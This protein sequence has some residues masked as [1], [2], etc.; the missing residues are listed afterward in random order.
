MKSNS[1]L[2]GIWTL[3]SILTMTVVYAQNA[4]FIA[5][6]PS[7]A[8]SRMACPDRNAGTITLGHSGGL[9]N[10]INLPQ[11][12]LC[13]G[14]YFDIIH[15][16]DAEIE[17][18]DP[19]PLTAPGIG[20]VWYACAPTVERSTLADILSDPCILDEPAPSMGLYVYLDELNGNA[21]FQNGTQIN[22]QS[23]PDFYNGGEPLEVWFAPITVDAEN[24]GQAEFEG[25]PAGPCVHVNT[26]EAFSVVYLTP[27]H[28]HNVRQIRDGGSG[29]LGAF[30]LTGGLPQFDANT[31]YT[32]DIRHESIPGAVGTV[33]NGPIG[34]GD[35]VHFSFVEE[36]QY[37]IT[38]TDDKACPV[39][40]TMSV[41][42]SNLV[43]Y[44]VGNANVDQ[45]DNVC[46]PVNLYGFN[47]ISGVE[48]DLI[49]DP[50]VFTYVSNSGFLIP[51]ASLSV[52]YDGNAAMG[53]LRILWTANELDMGE[54]VPDGDPFFEVCL[55]AVGD[56]YESTDA[57]IVGTSDELGII[58][59]DTSA[60]GDQQNILTL[61]GIWNINIGSFHSDV[62][63]CP[64]DGSSNGSALID[65]CGGTA[66][67]T[68]NYTGPE[69]GMIIVNDVSNIVIDGLP[70]G[71]YDF[72]ITDDSGE[73]VS[74][75]VTIATGMRH[76]ISHDVR[77]PSCFDSNDGYIDL[78]ISPTANY[79]FEW[80]NF[81]FETNRVERLQNGQYNV[82]VTDESGCPVT[83]S[84]TLNTSELEVEYVVTD[85]SCA[86]VEDGEI[87]VIPHGG[88]PYADGQ[89]TIQVVGDAA[90]Q[91]DTA[92]L[93]RLSIGTYVINVRDRNACFNSDTIVL[94][95]NV[96]FNVSE[97]VTIHNSCYSNPDS[98]YILVR[99]NVPGQNPGDLLYDWTMN[100]M[101]VNRLFRIG[102]G[103]TETLPDTILPNGAYRLVVFNATLGMDC[104]LDT[105]ILIESPPRL[106]AELVRME[107]ESCNPGRD[108]VLV[109]RGTGGQGS[110]PSDYYYDWSSRNNG[111]PA[112]GERQA[113]N[114]QADTFWVTIYEISPSGG[115]NLNC[116]H[117]TFF[118]VDPAQE[119]VSI[120]SIEGT[121]ASCGGGEDGTAMATVDNPSGQ[122]LS[123]TWDDRNGR[124]FTGNPVSGLHSGWYTLTV[125]PA[126]GGC[127]AIDSIEI[128]EESDITITSVEYQSPTCP[129]STDGSITITAS[130][131][132]TLSYA[133]S[134]P[135]GTD[136]PT[137]NNI[138]AGSY[139]VTITS[140]G[141]TCPPL[142]IDT[143]QLVAPTLFDA[144][145]S[146]LQAASCG[147]SCDGSA[148]VQVSGGSPPFN[149]TWSSGETDP[150]ATQ[151]CSGEQF[152]VIDDGTCSDTFDVTIQSNDVFTLNI[153]ATAPS[154]SGDNT[155]SISVSISGGSGPY[156]Y[157][158]G[159]G[160]TDSDRVGLTDGTYY[161]TVT[162]AGGCFQTD[163]IELT[164]PNAIEY[165]V[166]VM[167]AS[168]SGMNDGA[169]SIDARGGTGTLTYTWDPVV[170]TDAI[171]M[172]L[173]PGNYSITITDA[174]GCFVTLSEAIQ[175][176]GEI[177]YTFGQQSEVQCYGDPATFTVVDAAGGSGGPF[178]FSVD[179]GQS[180]AI[181]EDVEL[182]AGT[183]IVRI[184]DAAG[185]SVTD[186]LEIVAPN[187]L[188]VSIGPDI[189]VKL[190]D[191]AQ[192]GVVSL[193]NSYPVDSFV[194]SASAGDLS[195][196]Y[197]PA[198]SITPNVQ[199][200]VMLTIYDDQGCSAED[201]LIVY[202]D[203]Q[204]KIYI[205]NAFSPNND[206]IN[207][208]FE[209]YAGQG[210]EQI[211]RLSIYNRWGGKVHEL[212]NIPAVIGGAGSWDGTSNG[213]ALNPGV[214]VYVAE[215]RFFDGT[216][217]TYEG[218]INLIR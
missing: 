192:I 200:T 188:S 99:L 120:L 190:G 217:V 143:L 163:T 42:C 105:T 189:T 197:C 206:G 164:P 88:S 141:S 126:D 108:G 191:S 177:T 96:E 66:P 216:T 35:E 118:I 196:I 124:I 14:D 102:P 113:N 159:D 41:G 92:I 22:G 147:G 54:S 170:S 112:D 179:D 18:S 93:D 12:Y 115:L 87:I 152:V 47:A 133:W 61:P 4:Q 173:S 149:Y 73:S 132:G 94:E 52:I 53:R 209:I 97:L 26:A 84:F 138:G 145:F 180:V 24:G 7:Q 128:M 39:E 161:L 34:H 218:E 121:Q 40:F 30:S 194:W 62:N 46:V 69:S 162:D 50:T 21:H 65:I 98:G 37:I 153:D 19:D 129:N 80:S 38:V 160:S 67:F 60:A 174:N 17:D 68:I 211:N 155:G 117:D 44:E 23:I 5:L 151:L 33:T 202:V 165:T 208:V 32:I 57:L 123:Y 195:C 48:F 150:T 29:C 31:H 171:A 215:I 89:Y 103:L 72:T 204:R 2:R 28:E 144:T 15:N 210:A 58:T 49:W 182:M 172:D 91:T 55:R 125:R 127:I 3:L 36:G 203:A 193:I 70:A 157:E 142:I 51:S 59:I 140:P 75:T 82:T 154:C 183:H 167:Q 63:V 76:T 122:T 186:T 212:L 178:T 201:E 20:Y 148:T 74:T 101:N 116:S 16:G 79:D 90:T 185:C 85:P 168:C 137:L 213:E 130:G 10:D 184:F 25:S 1:R 107:P 136:A 198:T 114:L 175:A 86:S 134:D 135:D 169:I 131:S 139:S 78:T 109:I 146:D 83:A 43:T 110:S 6:D 95:P 104:V 64:D 8:Y 45:G 81:T 100:G 11:S 166:D 106:G 77:A 111:G 56:C 119:S 205:P 181:G 156:T 9:S 71:D 176:S 199:T 27:I 13:T 158:W 207:D 187:E 214:Y